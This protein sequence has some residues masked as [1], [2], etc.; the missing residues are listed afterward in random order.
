MSSGLYVF[1][2][3]VFA[4]TLLL[5]FG[6]RAFAAFQA[7]RST[8]GREDAYRDLAA[9]AAA[10]Q[11]DTSARL[12]SLQAELSSVSARLASIEKTLSSVE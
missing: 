1:S 7:A 6:V 10:G 12:A 8:Q 3:I 11:A 9:K 4:V 5:I 2:L